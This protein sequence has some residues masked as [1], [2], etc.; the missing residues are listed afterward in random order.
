[1]ESEAPE[2]QKIVDRLQ[3]YADEAGDQERMQKISTGFAQSIR[4][5]KQWLTRFGLVN[6]EDGTRCDVQLDMDIA[7]EPII[8]VA[9]G[10]LSQR[11]IAEIDGSI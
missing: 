4:A 9:A 11:A 6:A 1:M 8:D 7:L 10:K 2:D 3:D 5:I